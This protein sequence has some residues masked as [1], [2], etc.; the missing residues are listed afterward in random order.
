M[1]VA[2]TAS[3][4]NAPKRAVTSF[5]VKT[6]LSFWG[7]PPC[8]RKDNTRLDLPFRHGY[9]RFRR[10]LDGGSST[11]SEKNVRMRRGDNCG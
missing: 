6:N 11:A 2:G 3:A 10:F 8:S 1:R 4:Q 5:C 7:E 9:A